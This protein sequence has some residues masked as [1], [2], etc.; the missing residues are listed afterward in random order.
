VGLVATPTYKPC[1]SKRSTSGL[2]TFTR[3]EDESVREVLRVRRPILR[4]ELDHISS[5]WT[6]GCYKFILFNRTK[7]ALLQ[8]KDSVT[9]VCYTFINVFLRNF[10]VTQI[11]CYRLG[12]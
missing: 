6:L 1:R 9:L 2:T 7:D 11:M 4:A 12:L 8:N 10:I 3:S 5:F